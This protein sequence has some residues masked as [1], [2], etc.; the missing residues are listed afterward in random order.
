MLQNKL[1]ELQIYLIKHLK[2]FG[3]AFI[4]HQKLD[5][6]VKKMKI[7][8]SLLEMENRFVINKKL[9]HLDIWQVSIMYKVLCTKY[10]E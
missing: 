9:K 10:K 4:N 8:M 7:E 1:W 3:F 6:E 2:K 5:L